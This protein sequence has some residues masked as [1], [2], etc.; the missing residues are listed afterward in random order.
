MFTCK[1]CN[2]ETKY[3]LNLIKHLRI[4][5][6]CPIVN[7]DVGRDDLVH[8]LLSD[9]NMDDQYGLLLKRIQ[10]LE[11]QMEVVLH[12]NNTTKNVNNINNS[13]NNTVNLLHCSKNRSCDPLLLFLY[14]SQTHTH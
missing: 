13:F 10:V 14:Q 6:P 2:Y 11:K 1:R 4:I 5:K 9:P 3:K 7:E 8:E 12:K